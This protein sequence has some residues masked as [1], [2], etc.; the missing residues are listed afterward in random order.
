MGLKWTQSPS[1]RMCKLVVGRGYS[2]LRLPGSYVEGF[3]GTVR[4][5]KNLKVP[6][7]LSS[8]D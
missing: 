7:G 5:E 6:I 1:V 3:R 8:N 4:C 2:H